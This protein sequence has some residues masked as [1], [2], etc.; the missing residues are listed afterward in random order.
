MPPPGGRVL[1]VTG[2][3]VV[4]CY[5]VQ[6][7]E[8]NTISLRWSSQTHNN[9]SRCVSHTLLTLILILIVSL[10]TNP[11]LAER[12]PAR[13]NLIH[14][15]QL[16]E[17]MSQRPQCHGAGRGPGRVAARGHMHKEPSDDFREIH[18]GPCL[19]RANQ[20]FCSAR[21]KERIRKSILGSL[22]I[23]FQVPSLLQYI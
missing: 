9:A 19:H 18:P 16:E 8:A 15:M 10:N 13:I 22:T 2:A 21:K 5:P 14:G 20:H 3:F 12:G 7:Y 11:E 17:K 6:I 4:C 23:F 1:Q